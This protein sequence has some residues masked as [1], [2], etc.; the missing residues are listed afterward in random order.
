MLP[1]AGSPQRSRGEHLLADPGSAGALPVVQSAA[2]AIGAIT[3]AELYR[4][5]L[6]NLPDVIVGVFDEQLR[7]V[8]VGGE[9]FFRVGWTKEELLGHRPG[10]LLDHA[11]AV[12]LEGHFR[13]ALRGEARTHAHPGI[14]RPEIPWL[15]TISPFRAEGG[16][17]V[18]GIVV[19]RDIAEIRQLEEAGRRLAALASAKSE[20]ADAESFLRERLE[21]LNEMNRVLE[22][23]VDRKDVM[24]AVTRAAVPRLGDWCAIHVFFE[25]TDMVPDVEVAHVEP[26]MVDYARELV[27]RFGY[28]RDAPT[29]VPFVIRTGR[30]ELIA[31]ITDEMLAGIGISADAV[32]VVRQ[33]Q[34]HS[35]I[36]VPLIKWGR[37]LGAMQFVLSG[38][39]RT[40]GRDDLSLAEAM[41]GRIASALENHRMMEQ[42]KDI[43]RTLQRSLLPARLPGIQGIDCAVEYR[44][45]GEGVVVGGDFYDIFALDDSRFAIVIGDVCGKGPSAAAVTSLVRH[46]IRANAWR[47]DRPAEVLAH[48]NK[49]ILHAE[50]STFCT[51]VY[52]ELACRAD[53]AVLTMANGGHPPPIVVPNSAMVWATGQLGPLVGVFEDALFGEATIELASG[54][55]VVLYTDG[56]TDL[57]PPHAIDDS[58]LLQIVDSAVRRSSGADGVTA[59][60]FATLDARAPSP[61][62][63]DDIALL[64]L[65]VHAVGRDARWSGATTDLATDQVVDQRV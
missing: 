54:D 1:S 2:T 56:V 10:E 30:S 62:R 28:D 23:T 32:E 12:A 48:V 3:E 21:F 11:E 51:V 19:S 6:E 65:Q 58:G 42:Q 20:R 46:S 50:Q 4:S 60:I 63:D 7:Y 53:G 39:D 15:S 49:A 18:G 16:T 41:A 27:E 24:R 55:T 43:A 59:R 57:P 14:L 13:A 33:L 29:G 34:L 38:P 45:A 40:Y 37:V 5:L 47:G 26:R 64:V 44:A 25:R 22:V 17:I 61:E 52:G 35:A 8:L 9:A 31:E 36:T